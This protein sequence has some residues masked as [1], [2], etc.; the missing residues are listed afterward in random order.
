MPARAARGACRT[1]QDDWLLLPV[2]VTLFFALRAHDA[3]LP[4][5]GGWPVAE[6]ASTNLATLT[7]PLKP[8]S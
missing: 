6:G 7:Q 4:P 2:A 3:Y 1:A 5:P 8:N